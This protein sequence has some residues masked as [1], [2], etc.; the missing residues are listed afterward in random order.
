[1]QDYQNFGRGVINDLSQ[2]VVDGQ[3]TNLT[4]TPFVYLADTSRTIWSLV[5]QDEWQIADNWHL[6]SGLR[7]DDYSDFGGTLNPRIALVWDIN[8][9]LTTK[10]LYG[11]AFR[12]PNF[13]EQ[14]TQ[15]NPVVIGN[16]NLRPETIN[17]TELAFDYRP[18]SSLR[19][20][21]NLYYY[22]IENLISAEAPNN[23]ST[24]QYQNSGDQNGFGSEFE[25]DWQLNHQFNLRGNYAWQNARNDATNNRVIG[26]PEHH[27]YVA[28]G[29]HFSRQWNLQP[30]LNWIGG[31]SQAANDTRPPLKDYQTFDL[32]LRG[33]NLFKHL[34]LSASLRNAFDER[35]LEPAAPQIPQNLPLS[36]RSFYFEASVEF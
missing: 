15:N 36:G 3:L 19:T 24:P 25:W 27:V 29:W 13:S 7:Y 31:R 28:L 26:V 5:A 8:K 12:A 2:T 16:K 30:Q 33:K 1:L 10:L 11:R 18:L 22:E 32:T 34:N 35:P 20:S 21:L 23:D 14:G 9:L 6:T 4:G 17:T